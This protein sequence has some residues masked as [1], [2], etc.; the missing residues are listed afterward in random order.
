MPRWRRIGQCWRNHRARGASAIGLMV[1]VCQLS[2][3]QVEGRDV[4][5][6]EP[7]PMDTF[8]ARDQGEAGYDPLPQKIQI[9]VY[10]NLR[11]VYNQPMSKLRTLH[12]RERLKQ[13]R[14]HYWG[15]DLSQNPHALS[16]VVNTPCRCSCPMCGNRRKHLGP[17]LQER[18]ATLKQLDDTQGTP[19]YRDWETDRKS[20]R[21]NSSHSAKSRMPSSA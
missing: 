21:L 7:N 8:L 12:H 17:T 14:K 5:H 13:A 3:V 4:F 2:V 6:V 11:K 20:T 19:R 18:R 1:K 16:S 9:S 10:I 15:R